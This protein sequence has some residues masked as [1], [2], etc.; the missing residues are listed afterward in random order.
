[1]FYMLELQ[2]V[3]LS[4]DRQKKFFRYPSIVLVGFGFQDLMYALM[5]FV[6]QLKQGY[7]YWRDSVLFSNICT[8]CWAMRF[9]RLVAQ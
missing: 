9:H 6:S 5:E 1:M 2:G 4:L 7:C 3:S 8:Y